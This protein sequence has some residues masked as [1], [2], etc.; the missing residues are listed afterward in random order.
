MCPLSSLLLKARRRLARW[1]KPNR[2]DDAPTPVALP[3]V[4]ALIDQYG[5]PGA[6]IRSRC[7]PFR[8]LAAADGCSDPFVQPLLTGDWEAFV[9]FVVHD[10]VDMP[11]DKAVAWWALTP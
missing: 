7:Q 3:G 5:S 9:N 1:R 11:L 6:A 2:H 8:G 4:Q 10:R